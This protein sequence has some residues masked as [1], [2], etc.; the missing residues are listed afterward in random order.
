MS[1]SPWFEW[2]PRTELLIGQIPD[3][4]LARIIGRPESAVQY[5][6]AKL[7]IPAFRSGRSKASNFRSITSSRFVSP[8][9]T[10]NAIS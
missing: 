5:R 10:T 2:T 3:V 9:R 6:R 1:S 4:S 7:G 8:D